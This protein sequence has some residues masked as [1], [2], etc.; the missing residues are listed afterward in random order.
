MYY[1]DFLKLLGERI[2][3]IRKT[4]KI[5]QERLAELVDKATEHISFIERG[6]RAPSLE[7][8]LD[9]SQALDVSLPYLLDAHLRLIGPF[10]N[11]GGQN[12]CPCWRG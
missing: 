12:G 9:L 8:L 1:N 6:E 2:R 4:K 10:L 7:L 5:K 3:F 11:H